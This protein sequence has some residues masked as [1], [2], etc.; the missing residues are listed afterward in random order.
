MWIPHSKIARNPGHPF[1]QRL[2][3]ILAKERFDEWLEGLC[4]RYFRQGGRPSIPP[5]VYFRMLMIGYFEGLSSERAIA[6]R[7]AD[8][9]SLREFLGIELTETTPEHSTLSVWRKRLEVGTYEEVFRKILAIVERY[10]LLKGEVLGVDST[11]LEANAAMRSIIRKD[12]GETYREYLAGLAR[13]AGMEEPT[14]EEL[15]KFDRNRKDR[16]TSNRDFE[17]P[18]DPDAR[19]AKMKDGSTHLAHKA[20][21]AVDVETAVVVSANLFPADQGDTQSLPETIT[22][23]QENLHAVS[24]E[25]SIISVVTD[26]GYHKAS[27]IHDLYWD[28]GITTYIPERKSP[29]RRKW[30][31]DKRQC[32][33]FHANRRRCQS[34]YGTWLI[35]QRAAIVERVFAHLLETGGL[36]RIHLRGRENIQKRYLVHVLAYNLSIVM[37]AVCGFGTPRSTGDLKTL[38]SLFIVCGFILAELRF[39]LHDEM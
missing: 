16:K 8:S 20:E 21:N 2:N 19:I 14:P 13:E 9:L 22:Q 34:G 31:G 18:S 5:G 33:A 17:S 7:C 32:Q 36:R 10:G 39:L 4:E 12:T 27:L 3:Q 38:L 35:R 28:E 15:R 6:W 37:R 29:Q 1:Y 11:T 25:K 26:K 23:S 30:H 24:S